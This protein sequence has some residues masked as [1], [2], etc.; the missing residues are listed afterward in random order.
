M[1]GKGIEFSAVSFFS[2]AQMQP[3]V[4][5]KEGLSKNGMLLSFSSTSL[6][7]SIFLAC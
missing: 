1:F 4:W 3:T 5:K 2:R 7:L 6:A